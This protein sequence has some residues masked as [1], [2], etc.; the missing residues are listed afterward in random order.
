VQARLPLARLYEGQGVVSTLEVV[1]L[2]DTALDDEVE[3]VTRVVG[4]APHVVLRPTQGALAVRRVSEAAVEVSPR[5]W[6]RRMLP[7]DEVALTSA[8]AGYRWGPVT[9]APA[10]V[11]AWPQPLNY[12]SSARI[13]RPAGLVGAHRSRRLGSGSE[14]AGIRPFTAGDRL[15]WIS[16]RTSLRT[17]ELQVVTTQAEQDA[18]VLVV[19][20]ALSDVGVSEGIEGRASSLD[21]TVRAAAALCEHHVRQG[22][23]VGLQVVGKLRG[24]VA[25]RVPLG[26]GL[27]H[28]HRLTG[29]LALVTTGSREVA[30]QTLGLGVRGGD[31]VYV[32]STL[33]HPPVVT[34]AV[35]LAAHGVPV[36]AVD[37]LG[38]RRLD[39]LGGALSPAGLAWRMRML[40]RQVL[41]DRLGSAGVPVVAWRGAGSLDAALRRQAQ[42]D[43]LPRRAAGRAGWGTGR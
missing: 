31:V 3:Q 25:P 30:E 9:L 20:D 5:R 8:W 15:R 38:E 24:S 19:V 10:A 32:L 4:R 7:S 35:S 17:G 42:R 28:L 43:R 2:D 23:R 13:P 18:G 16:W 1:S 11:V 21:V 27:R 34:A 26:S 33:L 37:T 39:E 12:E 22:D 41:V 14:F 29:S 40:D 6:G 36:L